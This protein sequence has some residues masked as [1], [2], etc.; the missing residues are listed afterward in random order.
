MKK[1]PYFSGR[2]TTLIYFL[3]LSFTRQALLP[4]S[5]TSGIKAFLMSPLPAKHHSAQPHRGSNTSRTRSMTTQG[6]THTH[7]HTTPM[8]EWRAEPFAL[9]CSPGS[10]APN[11]ATNRKVSWPM[12]FG[13]PVWYGMPQLQRAAIRVKV[14]DDG[15][16][17]KFGSWSRIESWKSC[18][19]RA[20]AGNQEAAESKDEQE[21]TSNP[22]NGIILARFTAGKLVL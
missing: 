16:N 21:E 1:A 17:V 12:C 15:P 18:D 6:E 5:S 7:T 4:H 11:A 2:W 14:G 13:R 19:F 9:W 8:C 10:Y 20:Q 3:F 22:Q